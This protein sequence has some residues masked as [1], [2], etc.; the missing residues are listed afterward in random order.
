MRSLEGF[1]ARGPSRRCPELIPELDESACID[2]L[3]TILYRRRTLFIIDDVWEPEHGAQFLL[4]GPFGRTIF[5]TRESLVALHVATPRRTLRVR[6]LKSHEALA[7]LAE[8]APHAV[9]RDQ[10][11]AKRL[12]EKLGALPLAVKLAGLHLAQQADIAGR[13]DAAIGELLERR[14]A[15]LALTQVERR[16]GLD[17]N[18]RA[19]LGAIIGMSLDRLNDIDRLRFAL[20]ATFGGEPIVWEIPHVSTVWECSVADA[21]ATTSRLMQRGLVERRRDEYWMHATIADYAAELKS[22]M[23]L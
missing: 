20:L 1:L 18:A 10:S 14:D 3:R 7:L 17:V 6:E 21:E 22:T 4:T 13:I 12:C 11:A 15:R 5:T 16:L 2:R 9:R 8:L 23:R 19:S